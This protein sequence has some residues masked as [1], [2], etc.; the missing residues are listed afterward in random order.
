[1]FSTLLKKFLVPMTSGEHPELDDTPILN[2]DGHKKYQKLIIMLT[3]IMT[4]GRQDV[5]HVTLSLA[6]FV[7]CPR[8]EPLEQAKQVFRYLKK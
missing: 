7:A 2:D 4:I 6:R 5:C 1:M 8:K 3:W